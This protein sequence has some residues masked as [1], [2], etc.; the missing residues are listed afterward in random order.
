[1]KNEEIEKGIAKQAF[2]EKLE[3][4]IE[5]LKKDEA[6]EIQVSGRRLWVPADSELSIAHEMED[7]ENELEF[8]LKWESKR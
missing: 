1:M 6:Y 3:W 7:D 2:I 8:Q 5:T 4:L